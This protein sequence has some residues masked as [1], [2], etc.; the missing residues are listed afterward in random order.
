MTSNAGPVTDT[1][2]KPG[3]HVNGR[4]DRDGTLSRTH[5]V[6]RRVTGEQ[7]LQGHGFLRSSE[8]CVRLPGSGTAH[9]SKVAPARAAQHD[10]KTPARRTKGARQ[11]RRI[12]EQRNQTNPDHARRTPPQQHGDPGRAIVDA[13]GWIAANLPVFALNLI[14]TTPTDLWALRYPETH[15]LYV[16]ARPAGGHHGRR[17]LDHASPA[18]TL[19]VRSGDLATAPATVVASER[20]DEDPHWRLLAP[21]ELLHITADQRQRLTSQ[22]AIDRAPAHQLTLVD[23]HPQA[24]AS[25][26]P[27]IGTR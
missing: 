12:Q 3:C 4:N 9:P 13:V 26:Q 21:G 20:M 11:A 15:P 18:G 5:A 23:L 10:P 1:T 24:A 6:T 19:R 14:L 17:H 25:Q 16:L 27:S 2:D 22:N 8:L 7:P